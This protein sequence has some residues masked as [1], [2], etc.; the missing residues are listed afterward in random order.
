MHKPSYIRIAADLKN[1]VTIRRFVETAASRWSGSPEAITGVMMAV[2]EAA[3]NIIVHGYQGRP[4]VIEVEVACDQDAL[5]VYVRDRAP[6]FDPTSMPAPDVTLPLEQR[7]LGGM[8]VMMMRQLVDELVYQTTSDGRNEL[9]LV[10]KG[11]RE[12]R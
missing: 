3:T 8:G 5:K 6:R 10:K 11:V 7:P 1:L 2:N 9:M 4:G 12:A